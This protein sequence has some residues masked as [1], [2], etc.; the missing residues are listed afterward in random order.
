MK[1]SV[2]STLKSRSASLTTDPNL[3]VISPA[4]TYNEMKIVHQILKETGLKTVVCQTIFG[5]IGP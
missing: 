2:A 4:P 5:H 1:K 3:E